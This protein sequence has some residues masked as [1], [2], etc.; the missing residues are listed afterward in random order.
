MNV[1]LVTGSDNPRDFKISFT[2]VVLPVPRSPSKKII[3]ALF[4][5]Y[6]S[7]SLAISLPISAVSSQ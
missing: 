5:G 6:V 3:D 7:S 4:F 1:G 2:R